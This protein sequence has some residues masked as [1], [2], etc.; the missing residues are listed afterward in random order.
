MAARCP[1][2]DY[3]LETAKDG[4]L[5]CLACDTARARQL[6]EPITS[7]SGLVCQHWEI[8]K[9]LIDTM[10]ACDCHDC[11]Y[12]RSVVDYLKRPAL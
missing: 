1:V 12:V 9:D 3:H 4:S 2:C 8:C 7:G 5:V 10:T 11:V 6:L